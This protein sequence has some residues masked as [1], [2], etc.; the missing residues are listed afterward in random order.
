LESI[1]L[2]RDTT[3]LWLLGTWYIAKLGPRR[4]PDPYAPCIL[5]VDDDAEVQRLF[6]RVLEEAGYFVKV[7]GGGKEALRL[8]EDWSFE[9]AVVDMTMPDMDGFE[10]LKAMRQSDPRVKILMVS[11]SSF[12]NLLPLA[13][14][15][16]ASATLQKPF[17]PE[18]LL[19]TVCRILASAE[20]VAGVG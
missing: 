20:P 16:G 14:K 4:V 1:G 10:V 12:S 17:D 8:A 19:N 9:L 13:K 11:G 6:S 3:Q 2:P 15:L 18:T 7:A 5:V